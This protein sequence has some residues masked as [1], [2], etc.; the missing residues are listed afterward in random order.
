MKIKVNRIEN[1]QKKHRA[2]DE[3][4]N[5]L[6]EAIEEAQNSNMEITEAVSPTD[7]VPNSYKY[8]SGMTTTR[9]IANITSNEISIDE[10]EVPLESRSY[11]REIKGQ[12]EIS[13][14]NETPKP[15]KNWRCFKKSINENRYYF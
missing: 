8:L 9:F 13:T 2:T 12:I 7:S 14:I 4:L 1:R 3:H 5:S 15:P 10:E 11:G 6:I